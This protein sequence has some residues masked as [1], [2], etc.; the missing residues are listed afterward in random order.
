MQWI[1][2]EMYHKPLPFNLQVDNLI[3]HIIYVI[4]HLL[5]TIALLQPHVV[6]RNFLGTDRGYNT[7]IKWTRIASFIGTLATSDYWKIIIQQHIQIWNVDK[8]Y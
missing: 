6:P 8:E 5:L 1:L 3:F 7:N 2:T 4:A